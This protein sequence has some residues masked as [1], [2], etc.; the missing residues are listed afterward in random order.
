MSKAHRKNLLPKKIIIPLEEPVPPPIVMQTPEEPIPPP[1]VKKPKSTP[2]PSPKIE[3]VTAKIQTEKR[4]CDC[5]KKHIPKK[6]IKCPYCKEWRRDIKKSLYKRRTVFIVSIICS[7]PIGLI[8]VHEWPKEKIA[9]GAQS[10]PW[11][12]KVEDKFTSDVSNNL[13]R[14]L[15]SVV[16]E[17]KE[18]LGPRYRLQF[19]VDKFLKSPSG[20]FIIID[21]IFIV[22]MMCTY[23]HISNNLKRKGCSAI[24]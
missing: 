19:S 16:E 8:F 12:T 7:L 24:F 11:H 18:Y 22:F 9:L 3:N 4:I 21:S 17:V 2:A 6:A 23:V 20:W 10:Y 15:I 1:I 5:C 13:N 14:P